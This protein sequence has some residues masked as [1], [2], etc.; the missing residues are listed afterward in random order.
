MSIKKTV[1][2]ATSKHLKKYIKTLNWV[3]KNMGQLKRLDQFEIFPMPAIL[4]EYGR[5][6][7]KG[8][9]NG[10]KQGTAIVR[11][12]VCF[13]NYSAANSETTEKERD[14]ALA[15]FDF[16]ELVKTTLEGFQGSGWGKF[17]FVADEEDND[18][19]NFI[20][21]IL[22]FQTVLTDDSTA[23]DKNFVPVEPEFKTTYKRP[24]SRP[25][26]NIVSGFDVP[27]KT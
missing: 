21:T 22:E 18:H 2:L 17:E 16:C 10:I 13:E 12:S 7:W 3:D 8:I 27:T 11:L 14:I 4:F 1:F 5:I 23:K 24:L 6:D 25:E 20:V 9:G 26:S 15:F 19:E